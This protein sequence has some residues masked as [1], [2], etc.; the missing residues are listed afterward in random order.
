[1]LDLGAAHDHEWPIARMALGQCVVPILIG[2]QLV[3]VGRHQHHLIVIIDSEQLAQTA[4]AHELGSERHRSVT[5][6]RKRMKHR[7]I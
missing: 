1:M 4:L 6:A 7:H 5:Q 3:G 2:L